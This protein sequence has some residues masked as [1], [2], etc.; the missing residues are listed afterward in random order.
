MP[1]SRLHDARKLFAAAVMIA[2]LATTISALAFKEAGQKAVETP[3]SGCHFEKD[4]SKVM[5]RLELRLDQTL[6]PK[7]PCQAS[8]V[9][10]ALD[11]SLDADNYFLVSYSALNLSF[12]LFLAAI[13]WARPRAL[14][15]VLGSVLALGMLSADLCENGYLRQWIKSSGNV[16]PS[17]HLFSAT[18]TKW[19]ALAAACT[20]LG[21]IYLAHPKWARLA[22]L[23]AFTTAALLVAGLVKPYSLWIDWVS[24][25]AL[26]AFWL[27]ILIHAVIVAIESPSPGLPQAAGP[28]R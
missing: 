16:P 13:G 10:K 26:P 1:V 14:W 8:F 12:F 25:Y 9:L 6:A 3:K 19:G 11:R 27:A 17:A 28:G 5:L 23:P 22:A 2:F 7:A 18:A 24:N 20:L 21:S 15:I 4:L